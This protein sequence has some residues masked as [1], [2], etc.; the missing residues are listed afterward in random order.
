MQISPKFTAAEWNALNLKENEDHW[1]KAVDVL[2]DRLYSR[3]IDPVDV[4]IEAEIQVEAK[5][6]KFGFTILA[7]DLLLI[8][9]LQ[10]FKEGLEDTRGKSKNVFIRFLRDSPH[11]AEFFTTHEEREK[12]Y[13]EFRCGILHQA[14][15]QSTALV[16]SFG[17][18]YDRAD[19][20]EVVNRNAVHQSLKADLDDYLD[21][22]KNPKNKELRSSFKKKMDAISNRQEIT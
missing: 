4:L 5:E 1:Q 3:Y 19:G 15:I 8:E 7:I 10:A 11:F 14:E 16:W 22:L 13:S 18:L 9:T 12:F 21:A 2:R 17:E 20:L 6:R